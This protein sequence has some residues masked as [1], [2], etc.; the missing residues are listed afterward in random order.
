MAKAMVNLNRTTTANIK[1][2]FNRAKNLCHTIKKDER[3]YKT[4]KA[5]FDALREL[6]EERPTTLSLHPSELAKKS[7]IAASTFYRHYQ[8]IDEAIR[9][10]ENN[11]KRRFR[12]MLRAKTEDNIDLRQ[13]ISRIVYFIYQNRDYF[14]TAFCRGNHRMVKVIFEDIKPKICRACHLPK[15]SDLIFHICLSEICALIEIWSKESFN[16]DKM[17]KLVEDILYLLKTAR[18]HLITLIK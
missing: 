18:N 10:K 5:I 4:E 12:V 8:N 3:F 11:L 9:T 13:N 16:P 7:K 2:R 17:E 15:N 1:I 14:A 6:I